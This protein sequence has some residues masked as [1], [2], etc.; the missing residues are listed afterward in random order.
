MKWKAVPQNIYPILLMIISVIRI[1]I[2]EVRTKEEFP[3]AS[4]WYFEKENYVATGADQTKIAGVEIKCVW[5]TTNTHTH[6]HA[7]IQSREDGN[8]HVKERMLETISS[9][10]LRPSSLNNSSPS[11]T[12]TRQGSFPT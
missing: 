11:F 10:V 3:L 2:K 8:F 4:I 5:T 6:T 7:H 1:R 9:A 12:A